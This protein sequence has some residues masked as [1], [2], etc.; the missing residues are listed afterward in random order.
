MSGDWV[1]VAMVLL[2]ASAAGRYAWDGDGRQALVWA[3]AA[4]SN[5][6]YLSLV[7]R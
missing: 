1:L 7:R 5:T 4:L 3:G 6:A 2:Q